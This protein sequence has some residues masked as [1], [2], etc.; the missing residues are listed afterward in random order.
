[1]ISKLAKTMV[2]DKEAYNF[3]YF[4]LYA[5]FKNCSLFHEQLGQVAAVS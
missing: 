5:I 3:G 1:M 2:D 4:G